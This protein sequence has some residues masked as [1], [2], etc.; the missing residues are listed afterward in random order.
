MPVSY[1]PATLGDL[2]FVSRGVI[3]A[4]DGLYEYLL[5]GAIPGMPLPQLISAALMEP[6]SPLHY[7]NAIVAERD[8]NPVGLALAYPAVHFD[9]PDGLS[10]LTPAARLEHIAPLFA[11]KVEG[12]FYLHALWVDAAERSAGIGRGLLDRVSQ[13]GA[14]QGC[15]CFSLHVW[16]DNDAAL[17]LYEGYGLNTVVTLPIARTEQ[18]DHQG[19]M[20]L[21]AS[22][23]PG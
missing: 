14:E 3:A 15:H 22:D 16:A 4:G 23:Q 10:V 20:I 19:G 2:G 6:G 7:S 9:V 8:A 5:G 17:S 12:S 11:N 13:S 21:M 1:R 18:L